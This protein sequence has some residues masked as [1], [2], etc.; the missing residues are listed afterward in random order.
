MATYDPRGVIP[1]IRDTAARYGIDPD[2]AVKV[3]QSEG[4]SQFTSGIPGENSYGAFQLNT[5]GGL[6]NEFQKATGLDPADPGNEQATIDYALKH[7]SQNGWTAFHGAKNRYGFGPWVGIGGNQVPAT[8]SAAPPISGP[9]PPLSIEQ[10]TQP[11]QSA[12]GAMAQPSAPFQVDQLPALNAPT[13]TRRMIDLAQAFAKI[14]L[15]RG[16]RGFSIG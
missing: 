3:A 9:I 14:P 16:F 1:F 10:P 12:Q 8:P 5:Q 6:G 7:A 15:P 4:L 11:M 13:Q 2:V